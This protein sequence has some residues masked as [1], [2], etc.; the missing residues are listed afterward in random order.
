MTIWTVLAGIALLLVIGFAF[1]RIRVATAQR[2]K[3]R[4]SYF[5]A[6]AGLFS[7]VRMGRAD[8]GFPRLNGRHAGQLFDLQ[9][10]PDTLTFRKLPSLWL[11]VTVPAPQPL[12][13]TTDFMMR[14]T[15]SEV[16]S[17]FGALPVQSVT[18]PGFPDDL[19]VRTDNPADMPN[20]ELL[21]S[22]RAAFFSPLV[23]EVL[24]SPRGLRI[25][26]LAEEA[27]RSRYLIFRDAELG[28]EPLALEVLRPLLA[29][30][31]ALAA[32]LSAEPANEGAAA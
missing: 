14:P 8:H 21:Q 22:V 19:A 27:D 10:V 29:Q 17:R 25:V 31:L 26:W 30:C 2:V 1:T 23:K 11:M 3:A 24:L 32:A 4:L 15:G 9:V 12:T 6:C 13:A 16:F 5:D 7:D 28:M 18:P 20:G